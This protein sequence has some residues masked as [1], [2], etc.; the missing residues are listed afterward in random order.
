MSEVRIFGPVEDVEAFR[1]QIIQD[2]SGDDIMVSEVRSQKVDIFGNGEF[3]STPIVEFVIQYGSAVAAVGTLST[4]K[5]VY[6]KL[7]DWRKLKAEPSRNG[8]DNDKSE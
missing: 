7:K 6:T 1:E 3:G 2:I 5:V 8:A 4:I